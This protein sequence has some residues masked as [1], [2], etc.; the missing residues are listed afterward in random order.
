VL[1][2]AAVVTSAV[3]ACGVPTSGRP[4]AD[5]VVTTNVGGGGVGSVQPPATAASLINPTP[6]DFVTAFL[7]STAGGTSKDSEVAAA[8]AFMTSSGASGWEPNTDSVTV[9]RPVGSLNDTFHSTYYL[10]TGKFQVV[11][12]FTVGSGI[13]EAPPSTRTPVKPITLSFKV[14]LGSNG[15]LLEAPPMMLMSESALQTWFQPHAIYFWDSTDKA[16]IPDL[17]YLSNLQSQI[18]QATNIVTWVLSPPS[19]WVSSAT[20]SLVSGVSLVDPTIKIDKSGAYVVNLNA[21]ARALATPALLAYELRWSL[22]KLGGQTQDVVP[23]PVKIEIEA[24]PWVGSSDEGY[25]ARVPN[26]AVQRSKVQ[27]DTYAISGGKVIAISVDT[28]ARVTTQNQSQPGILDSTKNA[29]VVL[30]AVNSGASAA[31]LVRPSARGGQTLWIRR[32]GPSSSDFT[33]VKGL[34]S[35][36][37]SRPQFLTQPLDAVIVTVDGV[38]YLIDRSNTT[39]GKAAPIVHAVELPGGISRITSFSVAADNHRIAF[40]AD[41]KL[42]LSILTGTNTDT[43]TMTTPKVIQLGYMTTA[44]QITRATAV[45]WS[46]VDQLLVAGA[47]GARSTIVEMDA[48]GS[49]ELN[50][51]AQD[52]GALPISGVSAYSYDPFV[53]NYYDNVLLQTNDGAYA[54]RTVRL[55]LQIGTPDHLKPLNSP[56]FQN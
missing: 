21:N 2:I 10:V 37:M 41:G 1:A 20:A 22:G 3:S 13:L 42:Y 53:D 7:N 24:Q 31:A 46:S 15:R 23:R 19:A 47:N 43:P 49:L 8:K 5:K 35:G 48:Y 38:P 55:Q 26:L 6:E 29:N 40:V 45:A 16:L 32:L 44:A 54:G 11:G 18:V 39:Q 28:S 50:A 17:R 25:M 52:Y 34:P 14:A 30:A 9:V 4:V 33:P 56:F 12:Q 36:D 51:L 27:A